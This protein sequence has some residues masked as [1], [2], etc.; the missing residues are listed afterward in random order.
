MDINNVTKDYAQCISGG[1]I[2]TPVV[3][4]GLVQQLFT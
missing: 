1:A 4:H 3:V 2:T